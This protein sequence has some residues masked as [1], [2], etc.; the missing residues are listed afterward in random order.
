MKYNH[1]KILPALFFNMAQKQCNGE[2]SLPQQ[3][4]WKNLTSMGTKINIDLSFIPYRKI[5]H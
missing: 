1:T 5:N 2:R 3:W 4:Y